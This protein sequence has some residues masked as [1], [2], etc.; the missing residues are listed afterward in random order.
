LLI[1]CNNEVEINK[2]DLLIG[3]WINQQINDTAYT[4]QRS[5]EL[6][7]NEYGFT[8]DLSGKFTERTISGWCATPP[9]SFIDNQGNWSRSD[10]VISIATT[11]WGGLVDYKW[12]IVSV[13]YSTLKI[14]RISQTY[15]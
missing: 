9:V 11:Y 15:R 14:V 4:F 7:E 1:S 13:D 12:K 6:K 2:S 10:S 3:S 8:F 5:A